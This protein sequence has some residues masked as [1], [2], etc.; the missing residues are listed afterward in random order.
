MC[1]ADTFR[2]LWTIFVEHLRAAFSVLAT[3][4]TAPRLCVS[5]SSATGALLLCN[6]GQGRE[7]ANS[8][9]LPHFPSTAELC[10]FPQSYNAIPTQALRQFILAR[11][12]RRDSKRPRAVF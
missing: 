7:R 4:P 5:A 12:L 1:S 6:S 10:D 11:R 2:I 3:A 9:E 8:N